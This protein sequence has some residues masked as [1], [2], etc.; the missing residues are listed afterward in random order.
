MQ[1]R[2][3]QLLATVALATAALAVSTPL[4]TAP[5]LAEAPGA[6]TG[7]VTDAS[8]HLP[9]AGIRVC[10]PAPPPAVES[11]EEAVGELSQPTCATTGAN[12]EYTISALAPGSYFVL[13]AYSTLFEP[14]PPQPNYVPQAYEAAY[15]E[16]AAKKVTVTAGTTTPGIDA[17]LQVGGQVSGRVTDAT[18]GAPLPGAIACALQK[19]LETLGNFGCATAGGGGEYTISGLAAGGFYVIFLAE[20]HVPQAYN[21]VLQIPEA[22]LVQVIPGQLSAGINAALSPAPPEPPEPNGGGEHPGAA[23]AAPAP[24]AGGGSSLGGRSTLALRSRVLAVSRNGVARVQLSCHATPRCRGRLSLSL[25]IAVGHARGRSARLVP[26]GGADFSVRAGHDATVSVVLDRL[27]RVILG[28]SRRRLV[29][30]LR[31][32]LLE[33]APARTQA[34]IVRLGRTHGARRRAG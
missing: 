18:T 16:E 29:A 22:T 17:A 10:A 30:H 4:G 19:P 1:Y 2:R 6:I 8:T 34:L 25:R 11:E 26:L 21:G 28:A 23:G 5:A 14:G 3:A 9:A 31:V 33:P 32:R 20:G 15:T 12:G 13:F 24:G 27:G 7:T